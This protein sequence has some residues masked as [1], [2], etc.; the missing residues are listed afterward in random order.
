M[1]TKPLNQITIGIKGAGEMASAVAW[2]LY[3]ANLRRIL[4]L[5]VPMP[6]AVRRQVSF[7]EALHTTRQTVEGVTAVQATTPQEIEAAWSDGV[8]AVAADPQWQLLKA[9]RPDVVI[10]AILAKRNLG[11]CLAE[12]VLVIGLGPGF[13]AGQ[14][15]HLVIE[16]KRGHHLGRIITTG[17]AQ[18]NTGIP[19][20]IGGYTEKRVLRAPGDGIFNVRQDIG[21]LVKQNTLIGDVAGTE[22]RAGI[23]GVVRGLIRTGSH[24]SQGLKLGD[25]DPRGDLSYCATISDKARAI[26]GSVLEGI[27]RFFLT[28]PGAAL[29]SLREQTTGD[30]PGDPALQQLTNGIQQGDMRAVAEAIDQVENQKGGFEDLLEWASEHTGRAQRI[31]ITGPPGSGKSTLVNQL[32]TRFRQQ[33]LTVG[34]V[35]VDPSSLFTGGALFGDRLRMDAAKNDPG[36][37]VRSMGTR[38][39]SGGLAGQAIAVG[40]ILDASKKDIIIFETVGAGQIDLDIVSAADTIIVMTVPHA[41]DAIQSLKAGLMEIG[42]IFVVNKADLPGADGMQHDLE[43]AVRM[44]PSRES[45]EPV[46]LK[47]QA[48]SGAGMD[49]IDRAIVSHRRYLTEH[50]AIAPKRLQQTEARVHMWVNDHI[51]RRFWTARREKQLRDYLRQSGPKASPRSIAQQLFQADIDRITRRSRAT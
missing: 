1:L 23:D 18:P 45:W 15:T 19:G 34:V 26:G 44:R 8:V 6:L 25:I 28:P 7:C 16:T 17:S 38:G 41:G 36:V 5:E 37:Y 49:A 47:T 11:T 21:T 27:L 10:D 30:H 48:T 14:D 9:C 29:S 3:K 31:G 22:V 33:G 24:V 13:T 51:S 12:A 40:D 46:V 39:S 20:N 32:I 4:M 42:H 35:A 43:S 2:R 50:D